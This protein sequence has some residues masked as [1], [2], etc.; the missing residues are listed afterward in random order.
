MQCA[1][2]AFYGYIAIGFASF[3][4]VATEDYNKYDAPVHHVASLLA[5][6]FWPVYWAGKA[7]Y[8]GMEY[9][10]EEYKRIFASPN[11]VY[12]C[13]NGKLVPEPTDCLK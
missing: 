5:G 3:G 12:V 4:W 1:D 8:H 6:G 9:M 2:I 13:P 10:R 7:S 11:R